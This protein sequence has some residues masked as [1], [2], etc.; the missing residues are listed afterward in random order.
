[1]MLAS[2]SKQTLSLQ[3]ELNEKVLPRERKRHTDRR[4]ASTCCAGLVGGGGVTPILGGTPHLGR[5]YPCLDLGRRYPPSAGWG[6]PPPRCE[7]TN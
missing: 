6:T 4:V 3:K 1:M 2:L 5:G 7:L